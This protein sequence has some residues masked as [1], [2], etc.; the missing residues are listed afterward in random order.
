MPRRD[1]VDGVGIVGY[2][3][4]P[5]CQLIAKSYRSRSAGQRRRR[6]LGHAL[7]EFPGPQHEGSPK[8]PAAR[9]VKRGE[10][11]AAARVEHG[12]AGAS[13]GVGALAQCEAERVERAGSPHGE[14]GAGAEPPRRGEPD[15]DSGEGAG[16]KTHS[17]HP[18]RAPTPGGLDRALDLGEQGGRV[19]RAAIGPEPEQLLV[20]DLAATGRTDRGVLRRRVEADDDPLG[21]LLASQ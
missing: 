16:A 8:P 10:G 18:N 13:A 5:S 9:R 6:Q 17:Q 7:G 1:P 19:A 15:P 3:H 14:T 12:E 21:S 11:L 20:Q 4:A 2:G